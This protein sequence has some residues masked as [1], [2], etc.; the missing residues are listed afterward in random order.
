[1]RWFVAKAKSDKA[2]SS[3]FYT[4]FSSYEPNFKMLPFQHFHAYDWTGLADDLHKTPQNPKSFIAF[5]S[6][7]V[8]TKV[9]AG[10]ASDYHFKHLTTIEASLGCKTKEFFFISFRLQPVYV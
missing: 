1:M 5:F 6:S 8:F 3:L 9:A 2:K 10:N 4:I 7:T